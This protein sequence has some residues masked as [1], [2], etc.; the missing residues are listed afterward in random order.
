MNNRRDIVPTPPRRGADDGRAC[1]RSA[2][3]GLASAGPYGG[4]GAYPPYGQRR[5]TCTT[6]SSHR[7]TASRCL[8]RRL[9]SCRCTGGRAWCSEPRQS[10]AVAAVGALLATW[11]SH[12]NV[13][14]TPVNTTG[15]PSQ[16]VQVPLVPRRRRRHRRVSPSSCSSRC[17]VSRSRN[18]RPHPGSRRRIRPSS[19]RR[20]FLPNS[21]VP[22][23]N[24]NPNPSPGQKQTS[25]QDKPDLPEQ[26]QDPEQ[27]SRS[28]E[29]AAPDTPINP[30]DPENPTPDDLLCHPN[31]PGCTGDQKAPQKDEQQ[32]QQP[33][34]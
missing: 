14:T 33:A 6:T 4:P 23:P 1:G 34:P 8:L 19:A 12:D 18:R 17:P 15:T 22:A 21:P 20:R 5:P 11:M 28:A 30:G 26:K 24:P 31:P 16:Q 29:P 13:S 27:T 25:A 9:R 2:A 32:Q 10:F 7:S 3:G